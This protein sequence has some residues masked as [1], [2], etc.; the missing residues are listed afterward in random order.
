MNPAILAF[1]AMGAFAG[2]ELFP[3]RMLLPRPRAHPGTSANQRKARKARRRAHA[4]GFRNA[5]A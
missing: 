1:S 3:L 2:K 4:S 5:F